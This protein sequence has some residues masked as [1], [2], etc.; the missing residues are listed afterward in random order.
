M[1]ILD[2]IDKNTYKIWIIYNYFLFKE[3]NEKYTQL[4]L[5]INY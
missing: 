3:L 2:K 1:Q 5:C 4:K